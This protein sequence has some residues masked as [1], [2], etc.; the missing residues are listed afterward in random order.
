[1]PR[2][3]VDLEKERKRA[4]KPGAGHPIIKPSKDPVVEQVDKL[5]KKQKKHPAQR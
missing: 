5:S 3:S 4:H 1:M 2:R